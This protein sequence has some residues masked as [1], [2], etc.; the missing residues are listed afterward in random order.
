MRRF[1]RPIGPIPLHHLLPAISNN[2]V[3]NDPLEDLQA[4][5]GLVVR[6][7]VAGLVDAREGKIAGFADG[8]VFSGLVVGGQGEGSVTG[9]AEGG[10][11]GVVDRE[12][13]GFAAEPVADVVAGDRE[14]VRWDA[15]GGEAPWG[16]VSDVSKG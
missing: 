4:R 7:L 6:D 11:V 2:L 15:L 13:D 5:F 10:G 3:P 9:G 12:G 14:L 16:L 8:A 1:L